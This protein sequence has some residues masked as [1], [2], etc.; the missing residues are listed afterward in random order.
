[1]AKEILF[2]IAGDG[3][4]AAHRPQHRRERG[5]T[6]IAL[7]GV[8]AGVIVLPARDGKGVFV[9]PAALDAKDRLHRTGHVSRPYPSNRFRRNAREG[10][11]LNVRF[12]P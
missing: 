11:E 2:N 1:M 7:H 3:H 5:L 10:S 12:T 6:V 4:A 8:I 9:L